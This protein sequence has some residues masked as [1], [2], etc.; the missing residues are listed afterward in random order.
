MLRKMES[1]ELVML[2]EKVTA[3]L[4]RLSV[5]YSLDLGDLG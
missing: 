3:G 2:I 5:H 1:E 4:E